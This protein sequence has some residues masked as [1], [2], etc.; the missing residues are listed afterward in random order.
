MPPPPPRTLAPSTEETRR[1][2]DE[3]T[4]TANLFS[5]RQ[6]RALPTIPIR[7]FNNALKIAVISSLKQHVTPGC[8][9]LDLCCGRGGDLFKLRE[10]AP[11]KVVFV[12]IAR[13]SL[14][15]AQRRYVRGRRDVPYDAQFVQ[16]DCFSTRLV[17]DLG[18]PAPFD[19]ILCNFAVHYAFASE[20]M[21]TT[22]FANVEALLKP[23]TGRLVLVYPQFEALRSYACPA[24]EVWWS[25]FGNDVFSVTIPE[26][27]LCGEERF[28]QSYR[29]SLDH[30]VDNCEEFLVPPGLLAR[31]TKEFGLVAEWTRNFLDYAQEMPMLT[32]SIPHEAQFRTVCSLY[33]VSVYR[34]F[35][36]DDSRQASSSSL[37][38]SSLSSSDYISMLQTW[39]QRRRLALPI[40]HYSFVGEVAPYFSCTVSVDVGDHVE[41]AVSETAHTS[42][43]AAKRDAAERMY[44]R[45]V[46][47]PPQQQAKIIIGEAI[48]DESGELEEGEVNALMAECVVTPA[49][50]PKTAADMI[51]LIDGASEILTLRCCRELAD[52]YPRLS[53]MFYQSN[54]SCASLSVVAPANVVLIETPAAPLAS[55]FVAATRFA[56]ACP[57]K[58]LVV[59]SHNSHFHNINRVLPSCQ[60]VTTKAQLLAYVAGGYDDDDDNHEHNNDLPSFPQQPHN[61]II[62]DGG[63]WTAANF[64]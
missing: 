47:P 59:V 38:L 22:F 15:E 36:E 27:T 55:L 61:I 21:A 14:E 44:A 26:K 32:R 2:Y 16:S 43:A 33:A 45:V 28:G 58:P 29:F 6:R 13:N 52:S 3:I 12:D 42:K 64:C 18:H 41:L 7:D 35:A 11:S 1:H 54:G 5:K 48:G 19:V 39:C 25:S 51:V 30:A 24:N 9:V 49:L 56:D 8:R 31:L 62:P 60:R 23:R 46:P 4:Q 17:G 37:S 57:G 40:Y 20:R 50:D 63:V 53:F 34:S 10:L